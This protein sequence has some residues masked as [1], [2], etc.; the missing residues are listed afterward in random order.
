MVH[1]SR[2]NVSDKKT[3]QKI[4]LSNIVFVLIGLLLIAIVLGGDLLF[5]APKARGSKKSLS[6]PTVTDD[7]GNIQLH[8][9]RQAKL[10][11]ELDEIDNAQQYGLYAA[12]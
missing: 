4:K 3:Q 2:S 7:K 11:S 6:S 12:I 1:D 8:P 5:Q 9:E 10:D